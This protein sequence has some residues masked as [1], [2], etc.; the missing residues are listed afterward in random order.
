MIH[1]WDKGICQLWYNYPAVNMFCEFLPFG[2]YDPDRR[3]N[4]SCTVI[5]LLADSH[6]IEN[7]QKSGRSA[8]K[9]SPFV[10]TTTQLRVYSGICRSNIRFRYVF[11]VGVISQG[12]FFRVKSNSV[13]CELSLLWYCFP[14]YGPLKE[15]FTCH[16]SGSGIK[17]QITKLLW[18]L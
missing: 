15:L 14:V 18:K 4:S 6:R 16:K 13:F 1:L 17:A 5:P 12:I 7:L 9:C 2:T 10:N 3:L 11:I 8:V